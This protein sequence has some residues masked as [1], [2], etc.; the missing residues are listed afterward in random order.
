[1]GHSTAIDLCKESDG[2]L[3]L[4][5]RNNRAA[6]SHQI[7]DY[8]A[9]GR[10]TS[11]VLQQDPSNLKALVRRMLALE[12]LERYEAALDDARAVLRQDPGNDIANKIQHRLG[13]IVRDM[14][15]SG[16]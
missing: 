6:C 16:A 11:F 10:D 1:M 3:A 8:S 7:S 12:P 5:L 2:M 14:R 13:K 4:A 9:V 15:K